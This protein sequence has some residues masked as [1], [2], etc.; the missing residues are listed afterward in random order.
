[1]SITVTAH[2]WE[3]GWELWIDG[4]TV[5]QVSALDKAVQQVRDYLDT[6]DPSVDHSGWDVT[7]VPEIG[8]LGAEIIEARRATEQ[9]AQASVAAAVRSRAAARRLREAGYSVTDS[10]AILGV[11][12]GRVSQLTGS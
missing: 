9:A 3:H 10:A 1:M 5:T 8:P 12:R 7:V 2:H 4:E 11:S 6:V